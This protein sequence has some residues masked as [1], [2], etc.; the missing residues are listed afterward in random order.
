VIDT[1]QQ[2][3]AEAKSWLE[4]KAPIT[5]GNTESGAHAHGWGN[6]YKVG[7]EHERDLACNEIAR[8]AGEVQQLKAALAQV[9]AE[10]DA[11][12]GEVAR[13]T[14]ALTT[15]ADRLG[16]LSTTLTRSNQNHRAVEVWE[17]SK[18]AQAALEESR[19]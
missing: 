9:A 5:W 14:Q 2:K 7:R 11:A 12:L 8:L 15:A 10:R 17:W 13:L 19:K 4:W 3:Q 18:E 6:G 16:H 1:D